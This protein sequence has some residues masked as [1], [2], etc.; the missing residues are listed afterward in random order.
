MAVKRA[1]R[2]GVAALGRL[3]AEAEVLAELELPN[4]VRVLEIVPDGADVAIVMELAPG[5]SLEDL[6]RRRGR[7]PAGQVVALVAPI[8]LALG[9]AHRRGVVHGDIKPANVLLGASG[10]PL[11][12]DF[13][14]ARPTGPARGDLHGSAGYLDPQ[15]LATGRVGAANDVYALGVLTYL[16]LTGRLPHAGRTVQ[17]V[18]DAAGP[19]RAP[20]ADRPGRR[21]APAGR[22]GRGCAGARPRST[23]RRPPST[24]PPRC[25]PRS[26]RDG[27]PPG[28]ASPGSGTD[29][30]ARTRGHAALRAAAGAAAPRAGRDPDPAHRARGRFVGAVLLAGVGA[31][32]SRRTRATQ[33]PDGRAHRRGRARPVQRARLPAVARIPRPAAGRELSADLAGD[34]C[35]E[36]IVW[37]GTVMQFRPARRR[38]APRRLRLHGARGRSPDRRAPR[39]RL[40]LRRHRQPGL[41]RPDRRRR[42]LLRGGAPHRRALGRRARRH[43]HQRRSSPVSARGRRGGCD[44]VVVRP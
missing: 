24:S 31:P 28:A 34:G 4:V 38:P 33:R 5:G 7:L 18:L 41:L 35:P 8:A 19:G 25:G 23:G 32:R 9:E 2:D 22:G 1:R 13:G 36:Q 42:A 6:L 10:E 27:A 43:R 40:G 44:R 11:L 26:T 17:E 3:R 14:T 39:R 21:A 16:A 29:R 12:T 15:L 37:D 20:T 30:G